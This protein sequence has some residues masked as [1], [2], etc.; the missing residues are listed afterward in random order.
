MPKTVTFRMPKSWKE[1][2]QWIEQAEPLI[3]TVKVGL[4]AIV[5]LTVVGMKDVFTTIEFSPETAGLIMWVF[6]LWTLITVGFK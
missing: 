6:A 4:V 3:K 2:M 5:L 1:L